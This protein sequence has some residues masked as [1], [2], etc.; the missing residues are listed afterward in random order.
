MRVGRFGLDEDVPKKLNPNEWQKEM[1]V[2]LGMAATRGR[3]VI[4]L[5][6][7]DQVHAPNPKTQ[8]PIHKP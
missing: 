5:D 1:L 4:F 3:M 7:M 8:A 6:G 2:W